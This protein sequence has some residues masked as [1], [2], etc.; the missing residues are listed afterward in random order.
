MNA[1][2][3]DKTIDEIDQVL[4]ILIQD[5]INGYNTMYICNNYLGDYEKNHY[6]L[7]EYFKILSDLG[8]VSFYKDSHT[9]VLTISGQNLVKN[10]GF[11]AYID[12]KKSKDDTAVEREAKQSELVELQIKQLKQSMSE[13]VKLLED[14]LKNEQ[15]EFFRTSS[16]RNKVA[17]VLGVIALIISLISLINSIFR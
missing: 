15:S 4:D 3:D 8:F 12:R 5:K 7:M 11:S 2:Y 1:N 13:E 17:I 16:L 6:K 10:G 14:K 9:A